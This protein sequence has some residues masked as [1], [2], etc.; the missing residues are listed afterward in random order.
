MNLEAGADWKARLWRSLGDA[1]CAIIDATDLTTFVLEEIELCCRCLGL[2][3]LLFVGDSS[4]SRDAWQERIG[5]AFDWLDP[6]IYHSI[7]VAIWDASGVGRT[8][9]KDS[10][11]GFA[12]ELPAGVAAVKP[13]ALPLVQSPGSPEG[14]PSG[15]GGESVRWCWDSC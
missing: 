9:F 10:V 15:I 5:K 1:R 14:A 7:R 12:A 3:R 8:A 11:W 4:F 6:T 2:K 13:E